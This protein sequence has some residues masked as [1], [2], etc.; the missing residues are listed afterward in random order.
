MT[1]KDLEVG[2][3]LLFHQKVDG[4]GR[5]E[6]LTRVFQILEKNPT[7]FRW[8]A[9]WP[10]NESGY[11]NNQRVSQANDWHRKTTVWSRC[12]L[13]SKD[14]LTELILVGKIQ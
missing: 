1:Y 4:Y 2:Q 7:W 13:I 14:Q 9:V 3:F 10:V 6:Y 11:G 12:S 5:T 8:Q